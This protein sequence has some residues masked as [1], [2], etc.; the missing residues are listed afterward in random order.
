MDFFDL[1][2]WFILA[3]FIAPVMGILVGTYTGDGKLGFIAGL[4]ALI[5]LP[6]F[7]W[8]IPTIS[9]LMET[10]EDAWEREFGTPPPTSFTFQNHMATANLGLY[11]RAFWFTATTN[12]LERFAASKGFVI[13]EKRGDAGEDSTN[14]PSGW[15]ATA[16][17]PTCDFVHRYEAPD[18]FKDQQPSY[19]RQE[20][21]IRHCPSSGETQVMV[22]WLYY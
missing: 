4:G 12:S 3:C 8:G 22:I 11:G 5:V 18:Y 19:P 17:S 20:A 2:L 7:F 1:I 10:P 15:Y 9:K 13:K 16:F 14:R 21:W 6:T